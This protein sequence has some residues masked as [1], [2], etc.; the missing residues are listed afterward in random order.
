M[1]KAWRWFVVHSSSSPD[2]KPWN[3]W[4]V[5]ARALTRWQYVTV[6]HNCLWLHVLVVMAIM[7][8]CCS[9]VMDK[10]SEEFMCFLWLFF[11]EFWSFHKVMFFV[12][13]S[14]PKNFP[15]GIKI[16]ST[17]CSPFC[18]TH[19]MVKFLL[20]ILSLKN[21]LPRSLANGC[22]LCRWVLLACLDIWFRQQS[23]WH[24]AIAIAIAIAI[25]IAIDVDDAVMQDCHSQIAKLLPDCFQIA[26]L[27][28]CQIAR[29]PDH[30][31]K[32]WRWFVVHSSGQSVCWKNRVSS[33]LFNIWTRNKNNLPS[34]VFF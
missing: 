11:V 8:M 19:L 24:I 9:K 16:I 10:L 22:V 32:A 30:M 23:L 12:I 3:L 7:G 27:T 18:V 14:F 4:I 28:D 25:T 2:L 26:G 1:F 31:F 5:V 15:N 29:L 13:F 21:L 34:D 17:C 6:Q 20:I 33:K